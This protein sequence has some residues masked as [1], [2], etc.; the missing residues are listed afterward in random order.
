VKSVAVSE[1]IMRGQPLGDSA[2]ARLVF[3]NIRRR[4]GE[5]K[6]RMLAVMRKSVFPHNTSTFPF[7]R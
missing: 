3:V 2:V 5:W 4:A 1:D 7:S 6:D